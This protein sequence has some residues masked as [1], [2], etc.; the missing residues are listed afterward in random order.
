M[1]DVYFSPVNV[2]VSATC[3]IN[4]TNSLIAITRLEKVYMLRKLESR[5]VHICRSQIRN[6][7]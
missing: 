2:C 6:H 4:G 3:A 1:L 7:I 5:I